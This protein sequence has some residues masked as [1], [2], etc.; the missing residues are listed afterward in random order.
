[1]MTE[2]VD[3]LCYELARHFLD[4]VKFADEMDIQELA[5]AIQHVCEQFCQPLEDDE[6]AT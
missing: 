4:G 2:P 1:M 3:P 5:E 6:L